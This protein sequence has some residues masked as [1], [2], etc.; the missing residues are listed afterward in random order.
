M[1]PPMSR[2]SLD[3]NSPLTRARPGRLGKAAP[4][5]ERTHPSVAVYALLVY[6]AV[7]LIRPWESLIPELAVV[8][9]ERLVALAIFSLVL[10]LAPPDF[11]LKTPFAG[12]LLW[13]GALILST[14]TAEYIGVSWA[15]LVDYSKVLLFGLFLAVSLKTAADLRTFCLG[16]IAIQFLYQSKA[17]WEFYIHGA[18]RYMMGIWRLA[19]LEDTFGHPNTFAAT[20]LLIIPFSLAFLRTESNPFIRAFLLTSLATS[21]LVLFKTGSRMALLGLFIFAI[22]ALFLSRHKSIFALL[23]VLAIGSAPFYLSDDLKDRYWTMIDLDANESA[24]ESAAGRLE[25]FYKGLRI[26]EIRPLTGVGPD[27]F[28]DVDDRFP[29]LTKF[30]GLQPHNMIGQVLGETGLLGGLGFFC[31]ILAIFATSWSILIRPPPQSATLQAFALASTMTLFMLLFLGLFG[32]NGYRY[33]WIW[34]CGLA[35]AA[36]RIS[37]DLSPAGTKARPTP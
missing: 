26:L 2:N 3:R 30:P 9:F 12:L 15:F 18:G 21:I 34:L 20:T 24:T 6:A 10:L 7:Y 28:T 11:R 23:L 32:H 5:S 4:S 1:P 8:P 22:F 14:L 33:N 35:G 36:A 37:Q 13:I 17:L 27:C 31:F 16:W 29:N 19:G 25:G